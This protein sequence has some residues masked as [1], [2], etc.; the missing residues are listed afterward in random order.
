MVQLGFR[1]WPQPGGKYRQQQATFRVFEKHS[2]PWHLGKVDMHRY[3]S[4]RLHQALDGEQDHVIGPLGQ[5]F[6]GASEG[7]T[8]G[9]LAVLM[10][11]YTEQE[12]ESFRRMMVEEFS[13]AADMV[14]IIPG[15]DG[16]LRGTLR[17]ALE[18][19]P[20]EFEQMCRGQR[21][22][23]ILSGMYSDEASDVEKQYIASKL[24]KAV[25]AVAETTNLDKNLGQFVEEL[26]QNQ[27][28]M[29]K[30]RLIQALRNKPEVVVVG[31]SLPVLGYSLAW[32]VDR[33]I[34]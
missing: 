30:Q 18:T 4:K 2:T 10:L 17:H 8:L 1:T 14:Q 31:C 3:W 22:T 21:K 11:G 13:P 33:F 34:S 24:P 6:F 32:V 20:T 16:M 25:F 19:G 12:V 26:Q 9:P 7:G 23:L 29:D 5:G 15:R 28:A 27:V